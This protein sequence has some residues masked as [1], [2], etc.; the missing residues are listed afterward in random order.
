[1]E[2]HGRTIAIPN[3]FNTRL[4]FTGATWLIQ[5]QNQGVF[6]DFAKGTYTV[7]GSNFTGQ[8]THT[9]NDFDGAWEADEAEITGTVSG[10]TLTWA[11]TEENITWVFTKAG[12]SGNTGNDPF[13]GTWEGPFSDP[14][15][16]AMRIVA[17]NGSF[18]QYAVINGPPKEAREFIR[19]TYTVSGNTVNIT[20]VSIN[21]GV[22][23][24][25]P[26]EAWVTW[27]NL[28]N[29]WKEN[30]GGSP[31]YSITITGNS[32][33]YGDMTFTKTSSGN[34]GN[35]VTETL[36]AH[37][38]TWTKGGATLTIEATQFTVS[39][40]G[41]RDG[42]YQIIHFSRSGNKYQYNFR[43]QDET[44][45]WAI[46]CELVNGNLVLANSGP[47]E[48]HGIWTKQSGNTGN[49]F[50]GTWTGTAYQ[51]TFTWTFGDTSFESLTVTVKGT[52]GYV[53]IKGT[54]THTSN[55]AT[56]TATEGRTKT[57]DGEWEPLEIPSGYS[58]TLTLSNGKITFFPYGETEV[59]LT[60]TN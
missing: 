17:A 46:E 31:S 1:M 55:T 51:D 34:T 28:D 44:S 29:E 6:Y 5:V 60:K 11:I 32:F 7:N 8:M 20:M 27:A 26:T 12:S 18:S 3:T 30:F 40:T 2:Q 58:L 47:S 37:R 52:T 35:A 19:G 41:A 14:L 4:T 45:D 22:F 24:D 48:W 42:T 54:Y 43:P 53:E 10:N 33:T 57:D 39:N 38:G 9:K 59:T 15:P 23:S 25:N 56:I 50:K 13:A 21:P 49:P 16:D 36:E